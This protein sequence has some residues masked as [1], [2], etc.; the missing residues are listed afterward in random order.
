MTTKAG[1]P[2]P[3]ELFGPYRIV[4]RLGV[5]GMGVVFEAV[6]TTLNRSVALKVIS[7]ALDE[8]ETFRARFR[9]EAQGQA[10]L[11]SPH[12]VS[13]F[14]HGEVEGRLYI[15][16]QLVPDGDL[17]ALIAASG[18]PPV[19]AGVSVIAQVAAGLADAHAAGVIHRDLKPPNVLLRRRGGELHAYLADFGIARQVNRDQAL[20]TVGGTIGTPTFMAP[21]LHT[22]GVAGPASDIYALGCLLWATLTGRA[23][24][25]GTSDYELI[26]AHIEEPV[27]QFVVDSP[28]VEQVNRV[29]RISMAKRP[30]QRYPDATAM[31]AD[32]LAVLRLPDGGRVAVPVSRPT[33]AAMPFASQPPGHRHSGP[34]T[35]LGPTGPMAPASSGGP[36]RAPLYAGL[37]LV[38]LLALAFLGYAVV[39]TYLV[40]DGSPPRA[41]PSRSAGSPESP[42]PS[43]EPTASPNPQEISDSDRE[44]ARRSLS[45]TLLDTLGSTVTSEQADCVA[46]E[47]IGD[48]GLEQMREEGYFNQDFDFIDLPQEQM[49]IKSQKAATRAVTACVLGDR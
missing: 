49:T 37:A 13:V 4:R 20:T 6:D 8:D 27:P 15:A 5:G 40:D 45:R 21:E 31:R 34:S 48:V 35:P 32:L 12:V 41:A 11:D 7:P 28:A 42:S 23:P 44:R 1:Y 9:A 25:A 16:T 47:W 38:S 2:E 24:Y 10:S 22:G 26:R 29:L 43:D 30:E 33:G 14:A 18:A 3:G 46:E 39:D 19:H 36:S 17:G